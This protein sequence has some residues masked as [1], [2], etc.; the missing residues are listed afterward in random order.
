M[1][2]SAMDLARACG[3]GDAVAVREMIR[4]GIDV[5]Q[6]TK[7]GCF[8]IEHAALPGHIDIVNILLEA[9]ATDVDDPP[10]NFYKLA[11]MGQKYAPFYPW[12]Q[13]NTS[14]NRN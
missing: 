8:P 10:G 13:T 6:K 9:G 3:R 12:N 7:W 5:N 1:T 14:I 11:L 2:D 4:N